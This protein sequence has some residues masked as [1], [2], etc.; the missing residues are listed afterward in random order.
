MVSPC[1]SRMGVASVTES[2]PLSLRRL[3]RSLAAALAVKRIPGT[4]RSAS[5]RAVGSRPA[6]TSSTNTIMIPPK[7]R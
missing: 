3:P 4:K 2:L 5:W 7:I 1:V 6:G